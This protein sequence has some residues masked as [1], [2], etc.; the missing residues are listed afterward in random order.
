MVRAEGIEPTA[1]GL[2]VEPSTRAP[3]GSDAQV[4]ALTGTIGASTKHRTAPDHPEKHVPC[5]P[6]VTRNRGAVRVVTGGAEPLLSVREVAERL[7]VCRATVYALC[8]RGELVHVRISNAIRVMP[9]DLAAFI[10][11]QR[12]GGNERR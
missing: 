7:G 1:R 5:Y 3:S 6:V 11:T 4:G 8:E 2:R 10:E 9:A 12:R